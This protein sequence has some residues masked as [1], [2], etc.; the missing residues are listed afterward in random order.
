[1]RS[2]SESNAHTECLPTLDRVLTIACC[3]FESGFPMELEGR[4]S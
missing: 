4:V 3:R 2:V 1:M